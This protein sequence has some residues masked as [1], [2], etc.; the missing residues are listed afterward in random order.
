L[1]RKARTGCHSVRVHGIA[2]NRRCAAL[3]FLFFDVFERI[4][5]LVTNSVPDGARN[6]NARRFG[7][8]RKAHGY[9]A[10]LAVAL[11]TRFDQSCESV[12]WQCSDGTAYQ[13]IA[14]IGCLTNRDPDAESNPPVG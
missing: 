11:C 7:Q 13:I 10:A 4:R 14:I 6:A 12:S 3:E 5:E 2:V 9:I 1:R 8:R